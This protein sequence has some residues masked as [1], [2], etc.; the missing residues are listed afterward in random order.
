M[1][2]WGR[3]QISSQPSNYVTILDLR[4]RWLKENERKHK[5]KE[6]LKQLE[7]E[8]REQ[9]VPRTEPDKKDD[10]KPVVRKPRRNAS[11]WSRNGSEKVRRYYRANPRNVNKICKK[12]LDES[13][14]ELAIPRIERDKKKEKKGR[15]KN[16]RIRKGK[17]D[18]TSPTPEENL[19]EGFREK[20]CEVG[21][22]NGKKNVRARKIDEKK[23]T[24]SRRGP[25]K[26]GYAHEMK[27]M[28]NKLSLISVSFEIK[29]GRN[30]GV[31]RGSSQG[32]RN[33]R[34]RRNLDRRGPRKQRDVKMIWVRKDELSKG[35]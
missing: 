2:E 15:K 3:S 5:E 25:E 19:K 9:K 23:W 17:M 33:F 7:L 29:R 4:E 34:D 32:N 24:G 35:A 16:R 30:N 28:E 31:D 18:K 8:E 11:S 12:I 22:Q 21:V 14:P 13:E 26:T 27:E 1:E 10:Q 6:D 20:E